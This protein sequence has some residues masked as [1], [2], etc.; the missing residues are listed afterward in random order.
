MIAD[1]R[2]APPG[3]DEPT[4]NPSEATG[5]TPVPP[6][7]LHVEILDRRGRVQSRARID[8]LPCVIGRAY[9]CGVV[10]DDRFISPEHVRVRLDGA[11]NVIV[12]D[13]SSTNGLY[14]MRSGAPA[15]MVAIT[16]GTTIRIGQSLLRFHI[17][18]ELAMQSTAWVKEQLCRSPW[19]RLPSRVFANRCGKS[20]RVSTN[21]Y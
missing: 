19:T 11:G 20:W 5:K 2:S 1:D 10:L 6:V 12:E 14:D 3:R 13:L 15:A 21:L 18:S 9:A 17:R 4:S 7:K 16:P 8:T